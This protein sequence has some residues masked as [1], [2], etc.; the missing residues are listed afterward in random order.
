MNTSTEMT[1][2][3]PRPPFRMMAPNGVSLSDLK[4]YLALRQDSPVYADV[5][6][7]GGSGTPCFLLEDGTAT[8][9][10]QAVLKI[11]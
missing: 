1:T 10:L 6:E 5:R 9:D 4:V 7:N 11:Q 3:K 8:R 2:G